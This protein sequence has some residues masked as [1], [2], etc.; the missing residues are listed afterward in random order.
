MTTLLRSLRFAAEPTQG[1]PARHSSLGKNSLISAGPLAGPGSCPRAA[2][3]QGDTPPNHVQGSAAQ[4]TKRPGAIRP[5]LFSQLSPMCYS[6]LLG[7][8][9]VWGYSFC[10]YKTARTVGKREAWGQRGAD[11]CFTKCILTNSPQSRL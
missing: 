8:S 3:L 7:N 2:G 11:D 6:P 5:G 10:I 4:K 9:F 1:M